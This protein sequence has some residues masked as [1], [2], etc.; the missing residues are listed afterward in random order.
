MASSQNSKAKLANY[1]KR[2][3][4]VNANIKAANPEFRIII[5]KSNKY[6][7]SQVIDANW[8]VLCSYSD[9]KTVDG[10]T[11]SEKAKSAGQNLWKLMLEKNINKAAFD[12]NWYL[13]HGRV[14]SF[15]DWIR[16]SGVN[17]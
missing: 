9:Q 5:N 13:Y 8:N 7:K 15:A 10:V 14:K 12:R 16:E 4:R 17:I 11:K 6:I 2:K 1:L 3:V